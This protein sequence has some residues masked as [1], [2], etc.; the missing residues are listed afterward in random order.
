MIDIDGLAKRVDAL[1]TS[2]QRRI[3]LRGA[4]EEARMLGEG[5]EIFDLLIFVVLSQDDAV[6]I[7]LGAFIDASPRGRMEIRKRLLTEGL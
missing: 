1:H 3:L 4:I 2:P 5:P 6:D 7:A